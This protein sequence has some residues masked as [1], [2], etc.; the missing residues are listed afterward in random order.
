MPGIVNSIVDEVGVDG[1]DDGVFSTIFVAVLV[2]PAFE[3]GFP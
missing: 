2:T 1:V 3:T